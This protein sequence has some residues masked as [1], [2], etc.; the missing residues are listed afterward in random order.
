[1]ADCRLFN[2]LITLK[3]TIRKP[4]NQE[5]INKETMKAKK[6][7]LTNKEQNENDY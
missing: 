5:Q 2:I 3:Y 4:N 1:M 6:K 7:A